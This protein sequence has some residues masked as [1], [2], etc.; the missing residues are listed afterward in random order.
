MGGRQRGTCLRLAQSQPHAPR[1]KI[2]PQLAAAPR[3]VPQRN[4]VGALLPQPAS[5]V[6][7]VHILMV[8]LA[9]KSRAEERAGVDTVW[10]RVVIMMMAGTYIWTSWRRSC[11]LACQGD[12]KLTKMTRKSNLI[13]GPP[14]APRQTLLAAPARAHTC[15]HHTTHRPAGMHERQRPL[16]L[17]RQI[18][19]VGCC[20]PRMR[21]SPL[22]SAAARQTAGP[23]NA[24]SLQLCAHK[25]HAWRP[26]QNLWAASRRARQARRSTHCRRSPCTQYS[27]TWPP[28][29]A[30]EAAAAH[31]NRGPPLAARPRPDETRAPPRMQRQKSEPVRGA[32]PA[33]LSNTVH[34]S[35]AQCLAQPAATTT[36]SH[37]LCC[38]A[39]AHCRFCRQQPP[40]RCGA[41]NRLE[42]L[43]APAANMA[44]AGAQAMG[45]SNRER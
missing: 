22:R 11:E 42:I 33:Q 35:T 30:Q 29:Q 40:P 4:C 9:G 31:P 10:Q 36:S 25:T 17:H 45:F 27:Y 23:L 39:L 20:S 44:A 12:C 38:S 1:S 13:F 34:S 28:I 32:G 14:N 41:R 8:D 7:D 37:A 24:N 16:P 18:E 26:G 3:S 2:G 6:G 15:Q 43:P 21:T 5:Y 19:L